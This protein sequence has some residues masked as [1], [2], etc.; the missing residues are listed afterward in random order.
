MVDT[1]SSLNSALAVAR[2]ALSSNEPL[3]KA[4]KNEVRAAGTGPRVCRPQAQ[5]YISSR[6]KLALNMP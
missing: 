3:Y 2:V 1:S 6:V 5:A 4:K